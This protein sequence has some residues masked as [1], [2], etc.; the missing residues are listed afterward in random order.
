MGLMRARQQVV[1]PSRIDRRC[2]A[3]G[4]DA[5]A[6]ASSAT[7]SFELRAVNLIN[8]PGGTEPRDAAPLQGVD[9][10]PAGKKAY[11]G[12]EKASYQRWH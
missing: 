12:L 4:K 7:G 5:G 10:E 1:S 8:P 3:R 2:V 9:H 11:G 6:A